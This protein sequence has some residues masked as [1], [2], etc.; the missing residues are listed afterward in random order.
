MIA[1]DLIFIFHID[2]NNNKEFDPVWK[3]KDKNLQY[4]LLSKQLTIYQY[5]HCISIK[6]RHH[7][8][9]PF[10]TLLRYSSLNAISIFPFELNFALNFRATSSFFTLWQSLVL[11]CFVFFFAW[12]CDWLFIVV[13]V[14][15]WWLTENKF[16]FCLKFTKVNITS[17]LH[18]STIHLQMK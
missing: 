4:S 12:Y 13:D 9:C 11:S 14:D 7:S 2:H 16:C 17:I 18:H 8:K 15:H 5:K 1:E 10:T 6:N 3:L